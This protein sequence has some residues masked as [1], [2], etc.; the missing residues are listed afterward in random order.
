MNG[1][2]NTCNTVPL[3]IAGWSNL[4]VATAPISPWHELPTEQQARLGEF[5]S[6]LATPRTSNV[7]SSPPHHSCCFLAHHTTKTTNNPPLHIYPSRPSVFQPQT[8]PELLITSPSVLQHPRKVSANRT[9]GCCTCIHCAPTRPDGIKH[10][11]TQSPYSLPPSRAPTRKHTSRTAPLSLQVPCPE[12]G[13]STP[14]KAAC[15]RSAML[16]CF[17]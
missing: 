4:G 6:T 5:T 16:A 3:R 12:P 8:S 15:S 9:H 7:N 13:L 11:L 17:A 1:S 2:V 14:T 10:S